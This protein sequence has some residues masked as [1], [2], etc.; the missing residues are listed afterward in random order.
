MI[1]ITAEL[2]VVLAPAVAALLPLTVLLAL[3][4]V[5]SLLV[6]SLLVNIGFGNSISIGISNS[7]SNIIDI[8]TLSALLSWSILLVL[9]LLLVL[10]E[11][12]CH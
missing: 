10:L 7:T 5:V 3:V 6:V 12:Y 2:L 9:L 4:L 1:G 11:H 8:V